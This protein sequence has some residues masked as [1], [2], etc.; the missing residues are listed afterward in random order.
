M[1]NFKV[2]EYIKVIFWARNPKLYEIPTV[3]TAINTMH[4]LYKVLI[5]ICLMLDVSLA[6]WIK[7]NK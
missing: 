5:M 6:T 7:K 4:A 2:I 3:Y 1:P